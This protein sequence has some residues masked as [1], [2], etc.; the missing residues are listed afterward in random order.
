MKG[1]KVTVEDLETGEVQTATIPMHEYMLI[2]TGDCHISHI[3]DYPT[4][5]TVVLTIRGHHPEP[6]DDWRFNQ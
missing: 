5:G 2:R 3:E 4:S 6:A 1:F